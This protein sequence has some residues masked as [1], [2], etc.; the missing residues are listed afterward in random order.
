MISRV[1][2]SDNLIILD[3]TS[4]KMNSNDESVIDLV[5]KIKD[6]MLILQLQFG[7]WIKEGT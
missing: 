4:M 5:F 2:R 7:L 1:L 3:I 6:F